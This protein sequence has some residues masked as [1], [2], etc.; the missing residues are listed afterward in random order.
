MG[1]TA[2]PFQSEK[3]PDEGRYA[4]WHLQLTISRRRDQ[5]TARA[6][7]ESINWLEDQLRDV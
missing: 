4:S 7:L 5:S 2:V 3:S 1:R 6:L